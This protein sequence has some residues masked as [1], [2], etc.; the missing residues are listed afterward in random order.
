MLSLLTAQEEFDLALSYLE[1]EL[2][3]TAPT[4]ES[5]FL[6]ILAGMLAL[7]KKSLNQ[8]FIERARQN[9]VLTAGGD[10]LSNLGTEYIVPQR[11][12]VQAILEATI[13]TTVNVPADRVFVSDSTKQLYKTTEEATASGGSATLS[14]ISIE[15]GADYTLAVDDTLTIQ[16]PLVGCENTATV[17]DVL[18][19]GLD[20][21]DTSTYRRRIQN[22]IR[23]VGGG[24]NNADYRTW[25][26]AV[27]G[28]ERAFPYSSAPTTNRL[29]D[30]DM[31]DS[32]VSSWES[33]S[34]PTVTKETVD[35]QEGIR[36]IKVARA[37]GTPYIYQD[38]LICNAF[39]NI[40][41]YARGDG[42]SYPVIYSGGDIVWTGT[43]STTWQAFDVNFQHI[44]S[45]YNT[46]RFL[47]SGG[48]SGNYVEWDNIQLIIEALPGMST[49]YV[50]CDTDLD[51]DGIPD[52]T[53]LDS[54]K[55]EILEDPST[56]IHRPPLGILDDMIFVEPIS[57]TTVNLEIRG[58]SV[59]AEVETQV[60]DEIE[61]VADIYLRAI[62][63]YIDGLD[64]QYSDNS[65]LT[66]LT[67]SQVIQSVLTPYG[68]SASGI[69]IS[70]EAGSF[71]SSYLVGEGEELKL[72]TTTYV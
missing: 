49:I 37:V 47:T 68:G 60:K 55:A 41:G 9:L 61:D 44:D 67:L 3:Q 27:D 20:K 22:E 53:L 5:A 71:I 10:D 56:G 40:T 1:G 50:E 18:T 23:T 8:M 13:D 11:A 29:E 32:G 16:V 48:G 17:T 21:E 46:L 66:D 64:S 54:V 51:A 12:A 72:G 69:G 59:D 38:V 26:E 19:D 57:V 39:Y 28:V 15:A 25:A 34:A 42:T 62:V 70:V 35:P 31:E 58:L 43:V 14:L 4:H 6:R 24:G 33:V 65:L 63:P 45:D 36:N 30:G 52:Q 2:G 7:H